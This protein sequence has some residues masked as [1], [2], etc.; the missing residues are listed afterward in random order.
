MLL[1]KFLLKNEIFNDV[2]WIKIMYLHMFIENLK[3][4][5]SIKTSTIWSRK[6]TFFF[7]SKAVKSFFLKHCFS[8]VQLQMHI[9]VKPGPHLYAN[10]MR[11]R[12]RHIEMREMLT[13]MCSWDAAKSIRSRSECLINSQTLSVCSR[14]FKEKYIRNAGHM[15]T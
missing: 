3:I 5:Q 12:T 15:F 13:W 4:F 14:Y 11:M 8:K 9:S 10:A 6:L 1:S 2:W 7:Q